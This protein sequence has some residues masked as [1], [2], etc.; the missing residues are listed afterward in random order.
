MPEMIMV[1][2]FTG[3]LSFCLADW[4]SCLMAAS[5]TGSVPLSTSNSVSE[6]DKA[7]LTVLPSIDACSETRR[8][9]SFGLLAAAFWAG[10]NGT[11]S[12]LS[13]MEVENTHCF[14][15]CWYDDIKWLQIQLCPL[16]SHFVRRH[17][18]CQRRKSTVTVSQHAQN[19][20]YMSP[21]CRL[22]Q[23]WLICLGPMYFL[24]T[25][26][27]FSWCCATNTDHIEERLTKEIC[28][29]VHF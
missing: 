28:K 22:Q 5:A 14:V 29:Y 24:F 27:F 19:K 18:D 8:S 13:P 6:E 20:D 1:L 12:Y 21:Q 25:F 16:I 17:F 4:W 7:L 11:Q 15:F 2:F 10:S 3:D 23:L 9:E 26:L